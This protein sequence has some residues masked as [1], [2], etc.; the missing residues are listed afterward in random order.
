MLA[1][2]ELPDLARRAAAGEARA[3]DDLLAQLRPLLVRT[4]RLVVGAGAWEAEDAAQEALLD[5]SRA[6]GSL[7]DPDA[8][9]QWALRIVTRR[10]LK[11]SRRQRLL[12]LGRSL[13]E[14]PELAV[15]A[16][17]RTADLKRALDSLP[18][19]LRAVAVLRLY[20]GSS[21]QEVAT[22]L[23]CA[24]G[25]VKSQL[26]EARRRLAAALG[27]EGEPR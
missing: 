9:R 25:T 18:P 6:I 24:V 1:V 23:D 21:E 22:V 27:E 11:A 13:D 17:A 5:V 3:L 15:E 26:H 16:D 7:R 20:V 19:R 2:A 10:A 8:V 14:A 4:V 12:R